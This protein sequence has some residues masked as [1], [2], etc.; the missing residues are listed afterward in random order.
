LGAAI[1]AAVF[2]CILALCACIFDFSGGFGMGCIV[3]GGDMAWAKAEPALIVEITI[4]VIINA[5]YFML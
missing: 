4:P 2:L 3:T 1:G 5:E